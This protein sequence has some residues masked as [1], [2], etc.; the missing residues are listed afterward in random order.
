MSTIQLNIVGDA[1]ASVT[2]LALIRLDT[3]A[4]IP[5]TP[6]LPQ[7][8]VSMD[9][10][11][12]NYGPFADPAPG[13]TYSYTYRIT[14]PDGTYDQLSDTMEGSTPAPKGC[15][16]SQNDIENIY[17]PYNIVR[18]SDIDNANDPPIA[19]LTRI[20]A[21]L[22]YSCAE[23][24]NFFR[25]GPYELPLSPSSDAQTLRNWSAVLAGAWLYASRGQQDSGGQ[26]NQ[27][28]SMVDAIYREM[29]LFKGG[30]RRF[31]A[32]RRWP[33]PSAPSAT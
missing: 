30:V 2:L 14:W 8:F 31:N 9:S 26:S 24:N 25:D 16:A 10:Q 27:Y 5:V 12:W 11:H 20:Q 7:P 22:D 18:W 13:L 29:G 6:A 4:A 17:G 15:Y 33:T 21:A 1:P 32:P 28:Q 3:G 23:I 19:D